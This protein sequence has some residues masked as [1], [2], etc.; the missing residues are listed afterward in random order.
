MHDARS[1]ENVAR[2]AQAA[3]QERRRL[4]LMERARGI[5][6]AHRAAATP[7]RAH[8]DR[9]SRNACASGGVSARALPVFP[10]TFWTGGLVAGRR[11]GRVPI[12]AAI[13]ASRERHERQ[14]GAP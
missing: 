9:V 11:L 14:A 10:F 2:Q 13:L 6:P 4:Y 5:A 1:R 8:R 7:Q 3:R 12:L